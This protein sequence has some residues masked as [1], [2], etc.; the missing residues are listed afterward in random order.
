MSDASQFHSDR[1]NAGERDTTI[2]RAIDRYREQLLATAEIGTSELAEIEDHLRALTAE[3]RADGIPAGSAIAEACRRLGDPGLVA[4]E[5]ARV[6]SPFGAKLS[7]ARAWSAVALMFPV[8]IY[9]AFA[10]DRSWG[11]GLET[12]VSL[13]LCAALLRRIAWARLIVFGALLPMIAWQAYLELT[14]GPHPA[15]LAQL[16]ASTA[17]A[18]FLA[19]WSRSEITPAGFALVLLGP[20]FNVAGTAFRFQLTHPGGEVLG[21]GPAALAVCGVALGAASII[22]RGRWGAISCLVGAGA[23][24][25]ATVQAWPLVQRWHTDHSWLSFILASYVAGTVALTI[26]AVLTW[27]TGRSRFGS[28]RGILS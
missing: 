27:S 9:F 21:H 19:P 22:V 13:G 14:W 12:A 18:A 24:A 17:A 28:L 20:A 26:S 16:L 10:G 25:L 15:V 23:L 2:D 1:E 7:R 5:H 11:G 8:V 4:Q 6:R 3:L